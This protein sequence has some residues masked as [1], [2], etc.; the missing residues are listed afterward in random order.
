RLLPMPHPERQPQGPPIYAAPSLCSNATSKQQQHKPS[1][2]AAATA[3]AAAATAAVATAIATTASV[4]YGLLALHGISTAAEETLG[5]VS[6]CAVW[7]PL[8]LLL[9]PSSLGVSP[10]SA[11]SQ[12]PRGPPIWRWRAPSRVSIA[13]LLRC[14]TA[15]VGC[16]RRRGPSGG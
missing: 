10:A 4:P 3:I 15:A 16:T 6:C 9:R 11:A 8:L 7:G 2:A 5:T 13:A 14:Y 1:T 12:G